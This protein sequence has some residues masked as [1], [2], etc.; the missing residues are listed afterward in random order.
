[1]P[2]SV[3][4]FNSIPNGGLDQEVQFLVYNEHRKA[5]ISVTASDIL[6]I[7]DTLEDMDHFVNIEEELFPGMKKKCFS[8]SPDIRLAGIHSSQDGRFLTILTIENSAGQLDRA[9]LA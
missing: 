6:A 4:Y 2:L 8:V 3:R 9:F 7:A 5:H 1:M